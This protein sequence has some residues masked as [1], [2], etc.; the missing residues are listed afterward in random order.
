VFGSVVGAIL[1]ATIRNGAVLM[2]IP[3]QWQKVLL[4][5]VV[6]AAVYLDVRRKDR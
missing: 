5:V 6:L 1:I 2:G 4:G 3:D